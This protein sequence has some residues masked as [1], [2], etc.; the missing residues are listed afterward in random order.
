M[1]FPRLPQA[2][3]KPPKGYKKP[4]VADF[5]ADMQRLGEDI[6][7]EFME[8]IIENIEENKY[9]FVLAESTEK[10]KGSTIPL[11]DS[12][13][14][15]KAIFRNGTQVSVRNS[16]RTDSNLTNLELAILHEYGRKDK[17][18]PA[19][20]VWRST[21]RDFRKNARKRILDF[22]KTRKFRRR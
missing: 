6:A 20:P 10:R 17:S 2:L 4:K 12:R 11:V 3:L 15:I 9:G 13:K 1:L 5:K 8:T 7:Q 19:R 14:L 21:Y 18:I 16:K 22:L